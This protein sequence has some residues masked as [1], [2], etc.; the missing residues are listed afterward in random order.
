MREIFYSLII[1]VKI[2]TYDESDE[3]K[4]QRKFLDVWQNDD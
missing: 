2:I 4:R 3:S 1:F